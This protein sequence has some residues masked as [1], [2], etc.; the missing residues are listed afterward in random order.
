MYAD[1]RGAPHDK[2][3]ACRLTELHEELAPKWQQDWDLLGRHSFDL[4][5]GLTGP[6]KG[7]NTL[8]VGKVVSGLPRV[9]TVPNGRRSRPTST[10]APP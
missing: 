10:P 9:K 1:E 5:G 8:T 3:L 2:V 7:K 6:S 4:V